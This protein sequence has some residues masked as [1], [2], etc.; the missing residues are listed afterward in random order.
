MLPNTACASVVDVLK[1]Q[2]I[3]RTTNPTQIDRLTIKPSFEK[4]QLAENTRI[5][6]AGCEL[7]N[8]F[9]KRLEWN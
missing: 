5:A 4:T 1:P 9:E 8:S 7:M 2:I 6:A 3:A